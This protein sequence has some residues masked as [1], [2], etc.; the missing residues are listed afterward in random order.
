MATMAE[1]SGEIA[2]MKAM[3][4]DRFQIAAVFLGETLA[5]ALLGGVIGY[6]AGDRLA[7][8]VSSAVFDSAVAPPLGFSLPPSAPPSWWR[9]SA[10][11]RR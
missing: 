6:L 5:I 2:L 8:V 9:S 4:A 10:A 1:R 3:G 7:V 11:S